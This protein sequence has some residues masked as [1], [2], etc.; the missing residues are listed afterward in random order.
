MK[1]IKQNTLNYTTTPINYTIIPRSV[2]EP[3]TELV[4]AYGFC[5]QKISEFETLMDEGGYLHYS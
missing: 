2:R 3:F 1:I 5:H 4:M